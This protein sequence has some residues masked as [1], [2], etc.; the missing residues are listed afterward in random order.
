MKGIAQDL[1]LGSH[2]A[3][4]ALIDSLAP[5]VANEKGKLTPEAVEKLSAKLSELVGED[6]VKDFEQNRNETGEL[7]NEEGLPI[8]DISEPAETSN[9]IGTGN[10]LISDENPLIPLTQLNTNTRQRLRQ[11][12]DYILNILEEEEHEEQ[13]KEAQ[14]ERAEIE[15]SLGKRREAAA[16][17]KK[18]L[19]AAKELQKKIGKALFRDETKKYTEKEADGVYDKK[20]SVAF[21][22]D[23]KHKEQLD[24]GDVTPARL[25]PASRPTLLQ[26]PADTHIMKMNVVERAPAQPSHSN[27]KII[28]NEEQDSDDESEPASEDEGP[29]HEP[30]ESDDEVEG[31]VELDEDGVDFDFA[32]HQREVAMEYYKRRSNMGEA[33]TAAMLSHSHDEDGEVVPTGISTS[34]PSKPAISRFRA[35]RL[36]SAYGAASIS[37]EGSVISE[38]TA[39]TFQRA[40]R[41]GKLDNDS[42]LIGG[43][44]DSAS[45]DENEGIQEVLELLRKSEVYNLGPDGIHTV[46]S[47]QGFPQHQHELGSRESQELNDVQK[48]FPPLQRQKVSK[49]KADRSHA[50]R[51][52]SSFTDTSTTSTSISEILRTSPKLESDAALEKSASTMSSGVVE[53]K[54]I[55]VLPAVVE[56]GADFMSSNVSEQQTPVIVSAVKERSQ[57]SFPAMK[58]KATTF[59]NGINE[60]KKP[61]ARTNATPSTL[62]QNPSAVTPHIFSTIVESPSFSAHRQHPVTI[63]AVASTEP[64][65]RTPKPPTIISSRIQESKSPKSVDK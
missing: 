10:T 44:G 57:A 12:R 13:L 64:L 21:A 34:E 49:F 18:N 36:A 27:D 31:D 60:R 51:H 28:L 53:R 63:H 43:D 16:N 45:E 5:G 52:P 39:R 14:R 61:V 47:S 17:E 24:W 2:D 59:A 11:Q 65:T 1:N 8:I 48:T 19:E 25:R 29:I 32:R 41:T 7:L 38:S 9:I 55:P 40:V 4:K 26:G 35:S 33:A 56:R 37:L 20:K 42:R 15:K 58:E 30:P 54:P 62:S 46:K 23:T 22:D 6:A 3:F 50:G